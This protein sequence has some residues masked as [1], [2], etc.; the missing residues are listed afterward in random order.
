MMP[1][2]LIEGRQGHWSIRQSQVEVALLAMQLMDYANTG[3]DVLPVLSKFSRTKLSPGTDS[4]LGAM[5]ASLCFWGRSREDALLRVKELISL[6]FRASEARPE[7]VRNHVLRRLS[8]LVA[9]RVVDQEAG[10]SH[11]DRANMLAQLFPEGVHKGVVFFGGLARFDWPTT[12]SNRAYL[13]MSDGATANSMETQ[14]FVA[15]TL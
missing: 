5:L 15:V 12:L 4:D 6:F 9:L 14:S 10:Q 13:T 7:E 8:T 1:H 2:A 11:R 3:I